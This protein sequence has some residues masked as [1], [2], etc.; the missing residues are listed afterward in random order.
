MEMKYGD[1]AHAGSAGII[2]HFKDIEKFAKSGKISALM[3]DTQTKFNQLVELG[4]INN[5][6]KQIVIDPEIKP[7]FMLLLANHK[8]ASTVLHTVS[9][10]RQ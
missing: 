1:G 2:K 6:S 10:G 5:V 3:V 8:A 4:L 7:E 9:F